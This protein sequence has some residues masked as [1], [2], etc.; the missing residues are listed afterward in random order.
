MHNHITSNISNNKTH[1]IPSMLVVKNNLNK[2]NSRIPSLSLPNFREILGYRGTL[3][4]LNVDTCGL[5]G[6]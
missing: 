4:H 3:K 2:N 5:H 1:K 6:E